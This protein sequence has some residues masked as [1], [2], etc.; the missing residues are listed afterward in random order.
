[1]DQLKLQNRKNQKQ[2]QQKNETE[3][4]TNIVPPEQKRPKTCGKE[5]DLRWPAAEHKQKSWFLEQ[6][7]N[8]KAV[9]SHWIC[10]FPYLSVSLKWIWFVSF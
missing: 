5:Q 2:K 8:F 6:E 3:P 9:I 7:K 1:M 10:V 4:T